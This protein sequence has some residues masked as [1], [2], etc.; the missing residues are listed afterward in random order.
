MYAL[1]HDE[2]IGLSRSIKSLNK[3]LHGI[4]D[5][6]YTFLSFPLELAH[7][8][9]TNKNPSEKKYIPTDDDV[10]RYEALTMSQ[11]YDQ[12]TSNEVLKLRL[13]KPKHSWSTDK[14]LLQLAYNK[15]RETGFYTEYLS[16]DIRKVENQIK[17]LRN[18]IDFMFE[19]FEEFDHRMEEIEI[20]WEDEKV[21]IH[22]HCLKMLESHN[23]EAGK[24]KMPV[25]SKN[26]EED[27]KFAEDLLTYA[28]RNS[29]DYEK[30]IDE[31]TPGWDA[32]RIAQSDLIFM[33]LSITEFL[34]FPQIPPKV[35]LNEYLEL[36]KKYST[37]KSSK[38]LNGILDR[39][40]KDWKKEGKMI[41]K[42]RG[43]V[44]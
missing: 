18:L 33:V 36:A 7:F 22:K 31:S 2:E 3:S 11:L 35:T 14:D 5:N 8:I 23:V 16:S 20:R 43:L 6:F 25:L 26:E 38:F 29:E 21:S 10:K 42:G 28:Y 4:E 41:K 30:M 17:Y 27:L 44:E 9:K 19:D 12:L 39:L 1:M 37:P 32:E 40:M 34:N 13:D 24:F 15:V